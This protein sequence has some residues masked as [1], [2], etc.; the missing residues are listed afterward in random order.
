MFI[1]FED[2]SFEIL[3][4]FFLFFFD[5]FNF[6]D[7]FTFLTILTF[8][9]FM[10]Y[11]TYMTCMTC[12]TCMTC[13]TCMTYMTCM[14]CQNLLFKGFGTQVWHQ[15]PDISLLLNL[16]RELKFEVRFGLEPW[17]IQKKT[18]FGFFGPRVPKPAF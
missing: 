5:F 1:E 15:N 7:F 4:F 12:T 10:T 16:Y 17:H 11:M 18:K 8:M 6:F 14:T 13:M 2:D 3:R 9:T